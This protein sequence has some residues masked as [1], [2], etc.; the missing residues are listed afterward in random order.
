MNNPAG[1]AVDVP[2]IPILL[3]TVKNETGYNV[4]TIFKNPMPALQP[5]Y[6][7]AITTLLNKERGKIVLDSGLYPLYTGDDGLRISI[8]K[9]ATDAAF[10]CVDR[11]L[12]R[13][14]AGAGGKVWVGEW[15][16]GVS[17]P[18]NSEGYCLKPGAVCHSVSNAQPS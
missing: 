6:E 5:L 9:V 13:S 1:L 12:M 7:L 3:T 18:F 8:D 14:Y 15:D 2:N 10:R 16:T 11:Q 17:F 4:Q